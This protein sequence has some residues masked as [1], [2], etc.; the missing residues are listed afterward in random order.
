[1]RAVELMLP[2]LP[3]PPDDLLDES[4][5][6]A[7]SEAHRLGVTGIHNVEAMPVLSAFQRMADSGSLQLRVLFHPPVGALPE[8]MQRCLWSGVGSEWLTIG[9]IEL[10]L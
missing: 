7:Q 8:L 3:E 10:F 1:E 9:G 2:H 4:L 5:R 6:E